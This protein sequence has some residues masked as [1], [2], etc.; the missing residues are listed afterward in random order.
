MKKLWLLIVIGIVMIM[1]IGVTAQDKVVS[2]LDKILEDNELKVE[3]PNM[4]NYT[5]SGVNDD[6][7]Y[8]EYITNGLYSNKDE[9]GTTYYYRGNV[10]NNNVQFGEYSKDYYVCVDSW[11]SGTYLWQTDDVCEEG[12]TPKKI[13]SKGD[14]IYWKII[15]VNGDGSLRLLYNGTSVNDVYDSNDLTT[16]PLI[17]KSNYNDS[18][19]AGYTNKE[20][21][22]SIKEI[23]DDWYNKTLG[24]SIYDDM[25]IEGRF[26]SDS[27]GYKLG[28]DY[29]VDVNV[30]M[31]YMWSSIYRLY[32]ANTIEPTFICPETEETYGGAYR[33][34]VGLITADE[35]AYAGERS[36]DVSNTYLI[37]KDDSYTYW[38][39]TPQDSDGELGC[40][41]WNIENSQYSTLN[42]Y[43][44]SDRAQGVRPV[45]NV[46]STNGFI[47]TGDGTED[48]PYVISEITSDTN[49]YK[50]TVTIEEGSSVDDATAFTEKLDLSN[51]TWTSND[52]NI[53]RIENGKIIGISEGA[54]TITG[55]SS[56]GLTTYLI[57]VNVI[58][59]PV[60]NSMIYVGIGLILIL[61]LGTALYTVYRIKKVSG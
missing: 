22:S 30:S 27:S 20:N 2:F 8:P 32:Y 13:A 26:C 49:N 35:A 36:G 24:N 21:D 50:G 38:T 59:N 33:L 34:K 18:W 15:R 43:L 56:D 10:T 39:M 3:I 16:W 40:F 47:E 4:F 55:V 9:D 44:L 1:P 57:I 51:V 29:G 60:T 61:V 42:S 37:S 5:S 14:K 54:T 23:V 46:G 58:K 52:E 6:V 25:V 19:S 45:I 48:N 31:Y 41:V 11:G 17:G 7:S 12:K 28:K 53:A